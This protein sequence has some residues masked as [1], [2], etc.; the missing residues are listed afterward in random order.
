MTQPDASVVNPPMP[1][2]SIG[3]PVFNG[4][5]TIRA[6]ISA[7]QA[8]TLAGFELIISDNGSTDETLRI[9]EEAASRDSRIRIIR[10]GRNVGP[11]ANFEAVLAAARAPFFMFAAADDRIEPNFVEETLTALTAAPDAAA[12]APRTMIHFS[13]GR[14]REARGCWPI[15]APAW[16]RPTCFLLRPADNTRFYGLYRTEVMRE[17]Y[18]G[19]MQFHALDW[20]V[21]T[22]TLL[23]GKHLRS[24]SV[25][26]HRQGEKPDKYRHD[27]LRNSAGWFDR[28][29]PLAS[30]TAILLQRLTI[31]QSLFALPALLLLNLRQSAG[32]LFLLSRTAAE[33]RPARS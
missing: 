17:A 8:Q 21:S 29:F 31:G 30:M 11:I 16:L 20:A 33:K 27:H 4:A 2:V 32:I 25:I 9:C 14:R 5:K 28:V 26:L 7:A 15:K 1:K 19:G 13:D 18:L 10:Q 24:R 3:M 12:C 23:K 6:A 22:L